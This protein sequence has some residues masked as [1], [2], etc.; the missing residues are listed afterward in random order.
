[1]ITFDTLPSELIPARNPNSV[2]IACSGNI[3]VAGYPGLIRIGFIS[4]PTGSIL[5]I[6]PNFETGTI[7]ALCS[8][9]VDNPNYILFN[10][11]SVEEFAT[12]LSYVY[13][14]N[15]HF[16]ITVVNDEIILTTK[17]KGI[18]VNNEPF[19]YVNSGLDSDFLIL[20][21]YNGLN[22]ESLL[23]YGVECSILLNNEEISKA[24]L[25]PGTDNKI[26]YYLDALQNEFSL[27]APASITSMQKVTGPLVK[28]KIIASEGWGAFPIFKTLIKS[29][30]LYALNAKMDFSEFREQSLF[31]KLVTDKLFLSQ[32][33]DESDIW[34]EAIG[35]I[36]F[37]CF[38]NYSSLTLRATVYYTDNTQLSENVLTIS[39]LNKYDIVSVPTGFYQLNLDAISENIAYA[40]SLEFQDIS[41]K[42]TFRI[43]TE[44]ATARTY[45]FKNK[46]GVWD[47]LF[48]LGNKVTSVKNTRS[49]FKKFITPGY[50]SSL[51]EFDQIV[52]N[53][54]QEY[55]ATTSFMYNE[56]IE[57]ISDLF[58]C[59]EFYEVINGKFIKCHLL[60]DSNDLMASAESVGE[61]MFTYRKSNNE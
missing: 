36:Y 50:D 47:S 13:C 11:A 56:D 41:Q 31:N 32:K 60:D 23:N 49:T 2:K 51:G 40:Y 35:F 1:M 12:N 29:D 5:V 14:I 6:L 34:K 7:V 46:Y 15:K 28:Y 54:H 24:I 48:C 37:L 10:A 16:D 3:P 33:P 22:Q 26:E 18:L 25:K 39:S 44:P 59:S 52:S 17:E 19:W 42:I 43:L 8:T 38:N 20:N 30:E 53:S 58:N 45:L 57:K 55:S 21:Y 9:V 4:T 61:I 27:P